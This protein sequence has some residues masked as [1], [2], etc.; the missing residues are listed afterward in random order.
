[1]HVRTHLRVA[2]GHPQMHSRAVQSGAVASLG[3]DHVATQLEI[4]LKVM[5]GPREL[6]SA[7]APSVSQKPARRLRRPPSLTFGCK[8]RQDSN[9]PLL[10]PPGSPSP[11]RWSKTARD[12]EWPVPRCRSI[13]VLLRGPSARRRCPP[14]RPALMRYRAAQHKKIRAERVW[15]GGGR[16]RTKAC[17]K[18]CG[19]VACSRSTKH[20]P[21]R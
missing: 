8:L 12:A 15:G 1:M 6:G 10:A 19:R 5:D 14:C 7:C 16:A 9:T 21:I 3:T 13:D 17:R 4:A 20:L 2:A 11:S 18:G